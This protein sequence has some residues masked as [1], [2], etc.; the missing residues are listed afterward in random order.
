MG[1]EAKEFFSESARARNSKDKTQTVGLDFG[2]LGNYSYKRANI[3]QVMF[4]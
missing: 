3:Q 2:L 4:F 1:G